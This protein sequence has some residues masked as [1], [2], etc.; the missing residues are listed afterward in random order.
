MRIA[1]PDSIPNQKIILT[2]S[3]GIKID[4]LAIPFGLERLVTLLLQALAF[5]FGV[6]RRK[7]RRPIVVALV[8]S[9]PVSVV[10]LR[11]APKILQRLIL[12]TDLIGIG[13]VAQTHPLPFSAAAAAAAA[14]CA[15]VF[16]LLFFF[17]G[18][19]DA[20]GSV[21]DSGEYVVAEEA[22]ERET[23]TRNVA[24]E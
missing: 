14:F 9:I 1:T 22:K 2:D 10:Q 17:E 13:K 12:A 15:A 6:N 18:M 19:S 23:R 8:G 3:L 16:F 11:I 20:R 7:R 4:S 5:D 21:R 24:M